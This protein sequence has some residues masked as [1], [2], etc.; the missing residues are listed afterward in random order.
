[1]ILKFSFIFSNDKRYFVDDN[2]SFKEV[3][4]YHKHNNSQ[5]G[6]S[7]LECIKNEDS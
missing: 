6:N 5:R 1:M 2:N 4:S 3:I 7:F